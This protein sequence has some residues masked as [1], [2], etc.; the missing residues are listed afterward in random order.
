MASRI[1]PDLTM[2]NEQGERVCKAWLAYAQTPQ[3]T[4]IPPYL[5]MLQWDKNKETK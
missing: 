2:L 4:V 1:R 3:S 5:H